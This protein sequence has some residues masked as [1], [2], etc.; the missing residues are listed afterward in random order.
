M[1][2]KLSLR[3]SQM[4]EIVHRVQ[5]ENQVVSKAVHSLLQP[6]RDRLGIQKQE[7]I[8]HLRQTNLIST[9]GIN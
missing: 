4:E 6:V 7:V 3:L 9:N 8:S 5:L 1:A 2:K